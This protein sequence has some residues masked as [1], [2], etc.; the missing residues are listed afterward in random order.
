MTEFFIILSLFCP[1]TPL[2]T[3][4]FKN[5]KKRKKLLE[6]SF[7]TSVLKKSWS[8]A[9][10]ILRYGV[11]CNFYFSFWA[12]FCLF[13]PLTAQKSKTLTNEKK[14]LGDI[15]ILHMLT[16]NHVSMIYNSWDMLHK[17]QMDRQKKWHWVPNL[18]K[19]WSKNCDQWIK[20]WL[21]W[22]NQQEQSSECVL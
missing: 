2:T 6:I 5:L 15:I 3:Q 14:I 4:K 22:S 18:K 1:F 19:H 17:E 13:I 8:Y 12:I 9:I 11:R 10:L 20:P 21:E 7:Y 16:K